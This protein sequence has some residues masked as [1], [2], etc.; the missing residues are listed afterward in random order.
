MAEYGDDWTGGFE[1]PANCKL[2]SVKK[3]LEMQ[4]GWLKSGIAMISPDGH[5]DLEA[6]LDRKSVV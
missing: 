2:D 3:M 4:Q 5:V 6:G 1:G